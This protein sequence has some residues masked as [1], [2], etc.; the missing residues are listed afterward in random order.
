[1]VTDLSREALKP[2][3]QLAAI[4]S[5]L[6]IH[7]QPMIELASGALWAFEA[8]ARFPSSPPRPVDQ[9][10]EEAH[11]AGWGHP[12][13][14]AC[15]RA[16]LGR[17]DELPG[18]A[19]IAINVSPDVLANPANADF[20]AQDLDGVIVEVTE[21]R[22]ADPS[23]L[24]E[25]LARLR[26]HGALVAVDD[27]GTGYA[28][29]L[30]LA[31]TRPDLVKLDRTVVT[32]ARDSHE[33]RA[34]LEALVTLS[35]RLGA[36]VVGEGVETLA[37]LATLAEF[38][39]DYGQGWAIGR[40]AAAAEPVADIVIEN[41]LRAHADALRRRRSVAD[42]VS[43]APRMHAVTNALER[44]N[45]LAGLHVAVSQ[46]ATE[47]G[48][49]AISASVL[50]DDGIL[51]EI[52]SS[53]AAIDIGAYVLADYPATRSV[54]ETGTPLEVH[55]SDPDADPAEKALLRRIGQTSL[56]VVALG[57]GEDR[58]G[59]LE[60]L[61]RTHR[62]WTSDDISHAGV[63]ATHLATALLRVMA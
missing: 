52:T 62:S 56:L 14:L 27:L 4:L 53:G 16:A 40:P 47:L 32:G 25:Q 39:V 15:V 20:W 51:R 57:V 17:R 45:E 24:R 34:V 44:A 11:L 19:H 7:L 1:M 2:G 31:T 61:Q 35:H 41:C 8:L 36:A 22:A 18:N 60:F 28:G 12:L 38:D 49:E 48:V 33:Q 29:L 5:D 23:A 54:I 13:E 37:D 21:H 26:K 9:A 30:R 10:I 50:G 6:E 43:M 58:F 46:A 59:V 3:T 42:V 63:L 55:L